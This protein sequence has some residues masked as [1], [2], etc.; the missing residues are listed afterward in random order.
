MNSDGSAH[1]RFLKILEY[2][3]LDQLTLMMK[4]GDTEIINK[5]ISHRYRMITSQLNQ[6]KQRLNELCEIIKTKN[7][8]LI[9]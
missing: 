8:S 6:N 2:K 4:L 7:P 1:M 9:S 5:H 3:A